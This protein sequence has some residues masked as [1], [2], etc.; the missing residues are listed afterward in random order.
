M[1]TIAMTSAPLPS[2]RP[3]LGLR[4]GAALLRA[5]DGWVVRSPAGQH[6]ALHLDDAAAIDLAARLSVAPTALPPD[7]ALATVVAAL[8]EA[9]A[10]AAP[11][12]P[13]RLLL[14]PDAPFGTA[15]ST[16]LHTALGP[17]ILTGGPQD[18]RGL[19]IVLGSPRADDE[20]P[21][22]AVH[23]FDLG[24]DTWIT[25]PGMRPHDLVLRHRAVHRHA[26]EV[27]PAVAPVPG[28]PY[29]EGPAPA[30]RRDVACALVAA[31]LAALALRAADGPL[32]GAAAHRA[33]RV[34]TGTLTV[35]EHVVLPVPRPPA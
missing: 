29:L 25:P 28:A 16:A 14:R 24:G 12:G 21:A 23:C 33:L 10:A 4:P 9:G 35:G 2:P 13:I 34:D 22:D 19:S 18:A 1:P 15:L 7:D 30:E 3:A 11:R 27:D 8:V 20:S 32:P 6:F 26:A 5:R 17:R 31:H